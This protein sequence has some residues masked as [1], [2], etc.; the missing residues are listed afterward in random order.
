[1]RTL[2]GLRVVLE[3]EREEPLAVRLMGYRRAF[4]P[5]VRFG[6][7]MKNEPYRL[8]DFRQFEQTVFEFQIAAVA[9]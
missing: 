8:L 9:Y 6:L 5:T 4:K 2:F 1:M 7:A 3:D